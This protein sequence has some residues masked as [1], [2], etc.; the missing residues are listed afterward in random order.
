M[1]QPRALKSHR[2][3]QRAVDPQQRLFKIRRV[4]LGHMVQNTGKA[5]PRRITNRIEIANH[6]PGLY[7]LGEQDI[8]ATVHP[9]Q[10][11]GDFKGYLKFIR[12]KLRATDKGDRFYSRNLSLI[13]IS[14]P[15]RP[16]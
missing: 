10:N 4:L 16:Y 11:R 1:V 15:T 2:Q 7:P 6:R 3:Q 14:E 13:H 8:G 12:C 5:R 9:Y